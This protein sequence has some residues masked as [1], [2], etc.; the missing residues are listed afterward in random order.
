MSRGLSYQQI[1][2]LRYIEACQGRCDCLTQ[3]YETWGQHVHTEDDEESGVKAG[4][5]NENFASASFALSIRGLERRGL[6]ERGTA[7]R[8]R[9]RTSL[10]LTEQGKKKA[11]QYR[12]IHFGDDVD[13]RL[14]QTAAKPI[15]WQDSRRIKKTRHDTERTNGH[16]FDSRTEKRCEAS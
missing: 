6:I 4:D 10:T 9:R 2:T 15:R 16:H 12:N 3:M 1:F 14:A 13:R 7:P 11:E 5:L 8:D